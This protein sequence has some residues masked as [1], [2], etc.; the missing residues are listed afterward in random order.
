MEFPF[1]PR[2]LKAAAYRSIAG[3]LRCLQGGSTQRNQWRRFS[4]S[5]WRTET[6]GN[7]ARRPAAASG[8]SP[9]VALGKTPREREAQGSGSGREPSW[10]HHNH[11][12]LGGLERSMRCSN[13]ALQSRR[14]WCC[15]PPEEPQLRSISD[16]AS[17]RDVLFKSRM[18]C[19]WAC[20]FPEDRHRA[21]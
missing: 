9:L 10:E 2:S 15:A 12:H 4:A 8:W 5:A 17:S 20:L 14:C 19:V 1:S 7:L 11:H 6:S 21:S 3:P 13:G 18:C 16:A